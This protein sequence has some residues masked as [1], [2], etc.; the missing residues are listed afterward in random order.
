MRV[1]RL[2]ANRT[3][4]PSSSWEDLN[5]RQFTSLLLNVLVIVGLT[6]GGGLVAVTNHS[7]PGAAAP[8]LTSAAAAAAHKKG[9]QKHQHKQKSNDRKH[10]DRKQDHQRQRHKQ[11]QQNEPVQLPTGVLPGA[12]TV[13]P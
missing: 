6:L 1:A 11:R 12:D 3:L 2:A 10:K 5:M 13:D 8:S 9:H 4:P 7:T